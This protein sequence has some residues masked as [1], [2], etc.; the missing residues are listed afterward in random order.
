MIDEIKN[1]EINHCKTK[2]RANPV[3]AEVIVPKF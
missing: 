1:E 2:F 3:P